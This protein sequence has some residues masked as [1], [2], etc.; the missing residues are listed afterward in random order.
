MSIERPMRMSS[1]C[2][3]E[4]QSGRAQERD[5]L[6]MPEPNA[7]LQSEQAVPPPFQHLLGPVFETLPS[8]VRRVHGLA[9]PLTT[10]GFAD[11]TTAPGFLAWTVCKL[12]GL[13]KPGRNVPVSV[14]FHPD[15]NGCELWEREFGARRYASQIYVCQLPERPVLVERLGL[16]ELCHRLDPKPGGLGWVLVQWKFLRLALPAWTLP[17]IRCFES[18]DQDRFYFDIDVAFPIVGQVIHYRGWL[19]PVRDE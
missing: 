6:S 2:A 14:R 5:E 9:K 16:F 11:V 15:G 10:R 8:A 3:P 4:L 13:P 7:T 1:S 18:G 12:A 17:A 19:E